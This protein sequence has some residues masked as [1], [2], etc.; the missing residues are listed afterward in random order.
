MAGVSI[1]IHSMR[2]MELY[3]QYPDL[4]QKRIWH[5]LHEVKTISGVPRPETAVTVCRKSSDQHRDAGVLTWILVA[6][7]VAVEEDDPHPL[8]VVGVPEVYAT[9][10]APRLPRTLNPARS[11]RPPPPQEVRIQ[12]LQR[13]PQDRD[14]RSRDPTPADPYRP[15]ATT[16]VAAVPP[17]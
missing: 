8:E 2:M 6:R 7:R 16:A 9:L 14:P 10:S 12:L 11:G 15:A 3:Q 4:P 13:L 17:E 5:A 1:V